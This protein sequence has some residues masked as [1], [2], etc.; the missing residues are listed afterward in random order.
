MIKNIKC[1][2]Q[3][4]TLVQCVLLLC[5]FFAS[6]CV[7][8]Q[9]ILD[10]ETLIFGHDDFK[11][12]GSY[13]GKLETE[14]RWVNYLLF[15]L[16]SCF[17]SYAAVLLN[18]AMLGVF[19]FCVF[20]KYADA[21]VA[22]LASL[23][24]LTLPAVCE[25]NRFPLT[26]VASFILLPLS[27]VAHH[28]MKPLPFFLLFGTLFNGALSHFYFVLP[29]LFA[30]EKIGSFCKILLYWVLGFVVGFGV[31]EMM[32][33]LLCGSFIHLADWREAHPVESWSDVVSYASMVKDS[34]M[35]QLK[36]FGGVGICI[37]GGACVLGILR[38]FKNL[39]SY[40]VVALC[41]LSVAPAAYAQSFPAGL[42]V[43][44]RTLL[45]LHLALLFA[46]VLCM[47]Q[48]VTLVSVC[49]LLLCGRFT[50]VN[51]R[52]TAVFNA[53]GNR[54]VQQMKN[55]PY[56]PA[57]VESVVMLSSDDDFKASADRIKGNLA[58]FSYTPQREDSAT[59]YSAPKYLGYG[60]VYEGKN[61]LQYIKK[62]GIDPAHVD[63]HDSKGY[64]HVLC[65]GCLLLK[66]K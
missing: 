38:C 4:L 11:V 16:L 31:A 20:R 33:L 61:A 64:A 6:I 19:S 60:Y 41:V 49:C 42:S 25:L 45:C 29:L 36:M 17:D 24:S 30:N 9:L 57:D 40:V 1:Y 10:S 63:F 65:D 26:M 52:Q 66:I 34:L 27:V 15:P 21:P 22:L 48:H 2:V 5:L 8:H 43:A 53:I 23:T 58:L 7:A 51:G 3:R 28:K 14:G 56:D 35:L 59:W 18:Y 50:Q 46:V 32:T 54:W 47:R 62:R 37:M 12:I 13:S 55:L 44:V 39:P